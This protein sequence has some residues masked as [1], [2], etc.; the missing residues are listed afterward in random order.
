MSLLFLFII[1][2]LCSEPELDGKIQHLKS[3]GFD[4]VCVSPSS[5]IELLACHMYTPIFQQTPYLSP[6]LN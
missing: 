5:N 1:V 6:M 2:A 4:E 3:M